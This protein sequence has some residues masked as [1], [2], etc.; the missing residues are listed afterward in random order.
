MQRLRTVTS[1]DVSS[2]AGH[3]AMLAALLLG[4][5]PGPLELGKNSV[6]L[7]KI[8][9]KLQCFMFE[10]LCFMYDN[11]IVTLHSLLGINIFAEE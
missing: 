7:T 10:V 1:L 2:V 4:M 5:G 6:I 3:H 11:F 8:G 9:K